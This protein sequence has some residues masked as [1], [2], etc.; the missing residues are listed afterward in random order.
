MFKEETKQKF[1]N[2]Y[3]IVNIDTILV[4]IKLEGN[5]KPKR[6]RTLLNNLSI[7]INVNQSQIDISTNSMD[8]IF[9]LIVKIIQISSLNNKND[10]FEPK[11]SIEE[12][13]LSKTED[14]L[15]KIKIKLTNVKLNILSDNHLIKF[16]NV[17]INTILF[18]SKG[19]INSISDQ[20]S[21]KLCSVE[22]QIQ[23]LNLVICSN[24]GH[25]IVKLPVLAISI[26]DEL[27]YFYDL[28]KGEIKSNI[29]LDLENVDLTIKIIELD[30]VMEIVMVLVEG[31][32]AIDDHTPTRVDLI[33]KTENYRNIGRINI[34]IINLNACLYGDKFYTEIHKFNIE[35]D[36]NQNKFGSDTINIYFSPLIF[37]ITN[38]T[39]P[40]YF[41]SNGIISGFSIN[42]FKNTERAESNL[43]LKF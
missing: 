23:L 41:V 38:L 4:K 32:D 21:I 7:S 33:R 2:L 17:N 10:F 8:N 25:Q 29:N 27:N 37:S 22:N 15:K 6:E 5:L 19:L 12:I 31:L 13:L 34:K 39:T 3:R 35:I 9:K 24:T 20:T 30:K 26:N 28:K 40:F 42:L 18:K 14:Q 43:I 1:C 11:K 36:I 16:L